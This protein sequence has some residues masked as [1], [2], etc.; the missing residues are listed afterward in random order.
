MKEEKE[1]DF[2]QDLEKLVASGKKKGFLTYDEV[3]E[4]LSDSIASSE[5]IDQVF[6]ILDGKG[7]R[8]VDSGEEEQVESDAAAEDAREQAK[9]PADESAEEDNV[10]AEKFIPLDDPVK[11]YLKQMGSISLLTREE[12]I[13]LAKRIEE[14]EFKFAE[15]LFVN[16]Y[17]RRE[18]MN[19]IDRALKGEISVEDVVKDELERRPTLLKDLK[20][21]LEKARRVKKITEAIAS[22]ADFKLTASVN[23]QIIG[24]IDEILYRLH[25]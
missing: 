18:A 5:D 8:V 16:A 21:T 9:R 23:E 4:T 20:H 1:K 15:A 25:R 24:R 13:S 14:A 10:Y 17:A 3:N 11:M 2:Q 19:T 7:I 22:V 12:E 6:E